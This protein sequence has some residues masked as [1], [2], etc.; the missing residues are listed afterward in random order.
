[1]RLSGIEIGVI[2]LGVIEADQTNSRQIE[3]SRETVRMPDM[4]GR[5]SNKKA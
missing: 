2:E 3:T 4:A 1:M 5:K